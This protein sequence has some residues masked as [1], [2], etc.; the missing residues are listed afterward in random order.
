VNKGLFDYKFV[1]TKIEH[2][3]EDEVYF[4]SDNVLVG[5]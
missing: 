1:T 4:R 3:D 2:I 5:P